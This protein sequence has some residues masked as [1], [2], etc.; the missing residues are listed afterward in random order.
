MRCP[1]YFSVYIYFYAMCF[2]ISQ[3]LWHMICIGQEIIQRNLSCEPKHASVQYGCPSHLSDLECLR[4]ALLFKSWKDLKVCGSA[5]MPGARLVL[6]PIALGSTDWYLCSFLFS[7]LT[8]RSLAESSLSIS[9]I[10]SSLT[11]NILARSSCNLLMLE[12]GAR[13]PTR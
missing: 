2:F 13:D 9:I 10:L 7:S 6:G 5:E 11:R 8:S 4:S 3:I 12:V 1:Q